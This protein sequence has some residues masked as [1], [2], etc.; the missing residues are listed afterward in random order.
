M[1]IHF[2][3][4]PEAQVAQ[5]ILRLWV[6]LYYCSKTMGYCSE[7]QSCLISRI[8]FKQVGP[9]PGFAQWL[10]GTLSQLSKEYFADPTE[11]IGT[12]KVRPE[13]IQCYEL[14]IPCIRQLVESEL[15]C[16]CRAREKQLMES[17]VLKYG[18]K[19]EGTCEFQKLRTG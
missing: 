16:L 15:L 10:P 9:V 7:Q 11:M 17:Y 6:H 13:V 4:C 18:N 2:V 8:T 1:C 5:N 12:I 19:V 3:S 14:V